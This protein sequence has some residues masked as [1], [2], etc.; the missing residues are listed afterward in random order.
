MKDDLRHLAVVVGA[1]L[2]I[3]IYLIATSI[4]I[5]PDGVFYIQQAQRFAQNP[6]TA[7]GEFPPG[8]PLLLLGAHE[9]VSPFVGSDS[10]L[11]WVYSSQAVTLLCRV[12]ALVCLYFLGKLLTDARRSFWAVLILTFLPYPAQYGSV[13][14][15]EWPFLLFLT[16]GFWLLL[17]ALRSN[18]GWGL[19]LVG[20][21][22]GLGYLI[23]PISA[24]LVVYG[25]VGLVVAC[26][27]QRQKLRAH[28]LSAGLALVVCFLIPVTPYLLASGTIVPHQLRPL[29]SNG[30][31]VISSVAGKPAG[32]QPLAFSASVG[33]RLELP[34]EV[35]DPDG[36]LVA[37]SVVAV[38]EG[39]RPVYRFLGP[40][41][42]DCFLTISEY[43]KDTLIATYAPNVLEY[44]G[45]AFYAWAQPDEPAPLK[46]VYRFWSSA[47]GRH[48]YT[49]DESQRRLLLQGAEADRWQSEGVAF[50]AFA[51]GTQP[52][53]AQGVHQFR[54][55][56]DAPY[57]RLGESAAT[58]S[59]SLDQAQVAWH[60]YGPAQPPAG[61]K[62]ESATLRWQPG[63]DQQ[64]E[65][66]LNIIADDGHVR[67]GQLVRIT[68]TGPP[69]MPAAAPA[70]RR[71]TLQAALLPAA[72]KAQPSRMW[73]ALYEIGS[74][75]AANI[76]YFLIVPIG[77]GLY[78][79]L[80]DEA[81]P[82]EKTLT[83]A[84]I[85]VNIAVMFIRYVWVDPGP[86]RRYCLA[87]VALAI[88]HVPKGG[89]IMAHW[90]RRFMD[91]VSRRVSCHLS[92]QFW[93][94]FLMALAIGPM[95]LPKLLK[96]IDADKK[97]YR[98]VAGWLKTNTNSDDVIA[99]PDWRISFY[100]EREGLV[101]DRRGDPR[102][103]DYVVV[104][105][106]EHGSEPVPAGWLE[107]YS[108]GAGAPRRSRIIVYKTP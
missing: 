23:R 58:G 63:L 51:P 38:P 10:V 33:E 105:G 92:E 67:S 42:Y 18:R 107:A 54:S 27:G 72:L 12:L 31:A 74:A 1:A 48:F 102:R 90:I 62:V 29:T 65:Y 100:A 7:A 11:V 89:E 39:S 6:W 43:E 86:T 40:V 4:L 28:V 78:R 83:I 103:V 52:D 21:V 35:S 79:Y 69:E 9:L 53:D 68:V 5:T 64:G 70:E 98:Q 34:I 76:M 88:F 19:G 15:R 22:A 50:Y 66:L 80:K 93:F 96:P 95:C 77:L 84:V 41:H 2:A 75:F 87:L 44:D 101:Y 14:L 47:Q 49:I 26:I 82:Y 32:A 24:Q 73:Q 99:V 8:Y 91:F 37:L 59:P 3:G 45:I 30:P 16:L 106:S 60:A 108:V 71:Q 20:L 97:G 46:P 13:V 56:S 81:G 25:A 17:W 55:W 57:W 61:L 36:D 104:I 94:Y 85:V